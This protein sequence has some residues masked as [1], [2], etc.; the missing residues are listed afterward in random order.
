M[1]SRKLYTHTDKKMMDK[2]ILEEH[3]DMEERFQISS[4][5]EFETDG[6]EFMGLTSMELT[7]KR[8]KN[9]QK[10]ENVDRIEHKNGK[11]F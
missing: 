2:R 9:T 7:I 6:V 11:L 1:R 10:I 4:P 3:V 8:R 5:V